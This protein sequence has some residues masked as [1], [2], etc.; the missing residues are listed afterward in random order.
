ME[1]D[2]IRAALRRGDDDRAFRLLEAAHGKVVFA[3]CR[4]VLK[5]Q[6]AAEDVMQQAMMAAFE[7]R[8]QLIEVDQLRGWLIQVAVRKCFDAKRTGKRK[9]RRERSAATGEPTEVA[10][11][12]EL[13]GLTEDRR[14]L[15]ECIA[16]LDPELAVAVDLRYRDGMSWMQIAEAVG[17]PADTIRMRVQRGAMNS[18]RECLASKEVVP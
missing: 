11:M 6:S 8:R 17:M 10:S 7:N 4:R 3:R 2:E 5:D 15:E 16:A 14:A 13:F 18:L 1:D 12:V 9:D